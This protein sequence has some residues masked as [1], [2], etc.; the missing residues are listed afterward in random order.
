MKHFAVTLTL[1][2]CPQGWASASTQ[3]CMCCGRVLCG[4]GGGG[5]YLC[6]DCL[7]KMR[8]GEVANAMRLAET[9]PERDRALQP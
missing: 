8:T 1:V 2:E 4:M 6:E 7:C 3:A 9:P 5:N